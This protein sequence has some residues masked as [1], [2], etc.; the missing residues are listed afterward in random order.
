LGDAV[1]RQAQSFRGAEANDEAIP[2]Y[3][4]CGFRAQPEDVQRVA[5]PAVLPRPGLRKLDGT[6][7][8]DRGALYRLARGRS[9]ISDRFAILNPKL[10][11]FH[12]LY[13]LRDHVY[14]IPDLQCAVFF[15]QSEGCLRLLDVVGAQVPKFTRLYPYLAHEQD[16]VIEFHFFSDKMGVRQA[17]L[18]PCPH[19]NCFVKGRF[20]V[21]KLVFP[22]TGKA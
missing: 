13:G 4:H 21:E 14:E 20:P 22:A 3:R 1:A 12:A 5:V 17:H 6:R 15:T 8:E 2:F 10:V 19:D 18:A 16:R 7:P 11:M 9:P